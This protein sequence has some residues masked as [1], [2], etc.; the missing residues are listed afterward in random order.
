[1]LRVGT[2][3]GRIIEKLR[4]YAVLD[5]GSAAKSLTDRVFAL[6][7]PSQAAVLRGL[8]TTDGTVANYGNK[9]QYVALDSVS[10]ELLRQ[11]QLLLLGF[12]IKAKIYENRRALGQDTAILPDGCG[13]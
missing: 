2:C 9:S 6:D 10:L 4:E 8:F 12:G 7:R 11:V 13:G 1:M 3:V 5:A